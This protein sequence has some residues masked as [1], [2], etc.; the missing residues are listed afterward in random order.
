[1][2]ITTCSTQIFVIVKFLFKVILHSTEELCIIYKIL[3]FTSKISTLFWFKRIT[4]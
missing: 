1:M 2:L 3:L 4:L